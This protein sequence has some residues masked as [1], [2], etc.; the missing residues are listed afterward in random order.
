MHLS[1]QMFASFNTERMNGRILKLQLGYYNEISWAESLQYVLFF[2]CNLLKCDLG[3]SHLASGKN[4][5]PLQI[6][7]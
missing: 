6:Q 5:K 3:K 1:V 4:V 7:V 2:F